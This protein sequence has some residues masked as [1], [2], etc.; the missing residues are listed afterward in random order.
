MT[1]TYR[2]KW[3]HAGAII[4]QRNNV[5]QV[6]INSGGKR[7]RKT[8]KTLPEAKTYA[9]QKHIELKN[10]GQAAFDL[11]DK[12]RLDASEAIITLHGTPLAEAAKFF[13][14]HHKPIGG[15]R[16]MSQLLDEYILRKQADNLRPRSLDTIRATVG[17]L[18][19]TF[20]DRGV[21][22]VTS[23][24][25]TAWLDEQG[26]KGETRKIYIRYARLFFK[27]AQKMGL[28]EQNP[29]LQLDF[30]KVDRK[31][32]QV[33]TISETQRIMNTTERIYPRLVPRLAIGFFAG[34]RFSEIDLLDWDAIDFDSRLIRV[35]AK[36]AKT[37]S[38]RHAA[39][40]NNLIT[41]LLPH[42]KNKGAV[43][44]PTITRRRWLNRILKETGIRWIRNGPRHS[45]ASYHLAMYQDASKTEHQLGHRN[46][47]ILYN[48]YRALVTPVDA[49]SYWNIYPKRKNKIV[50]LSSV[51]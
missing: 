20:G 28:V 15:V 16:T 40:S 18:V 32:P 27:F 22:T 33:F 35:D 21:H 11:T 30:P 8:L 50:K 4:R 14:Q 17:R 25:L 2:R 41:W 26:Y 42:R 3:F 13:I 19:R 6:E 34:L 51:S 12:Q 44:P 37:R 10:K 38:Q 36:I 9:E 45:F 29:A 1:K 5:F 7:M 23:M 46:D 47:N 49:E 31:M 43:A 24:E 48:H 39:I